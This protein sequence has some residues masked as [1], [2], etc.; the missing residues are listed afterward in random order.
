MG[1]DETVDLGQGRSKDVVSERGIGRV[2]LDFLLAIYR[3][4]KNRGYTM[5]FWGDVIH[6]YPELVDALPRDMIALEWGYEADHPFDTYNAIFER[7][8]MPF[9]VCPGTSSWRT[10]AGRTHNALEN[11]RNAAENGLKHGAVGYL[12]T[13][14]GDEGHWQPLPVS[15]LGFAYGAAV[16]WG[17]EHNR[18]I[19]IWEALSAYAFEDPSGVMGKLVFDLGNVHNPI[20]FPIHNSTI[21][22]NILQADPEKLLAYLGT[23][24]VDGLAERLQQ[25]LRG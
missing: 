23:N 25:T 14:W 6:N 18:Q 22:F 1:C 3:Q 9:Y 21:L 15:Y 4:V 20:D 13:D 24:P 10:I 11:L 12:N 8:G 5:Q 2:Y 16:S 19:P 7:S 17:Y